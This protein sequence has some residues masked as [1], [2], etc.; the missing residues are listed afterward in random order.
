MVMGLQL[1]ACTTH[2]TVLTVFVVVGLAVVEAAEHNK[3]GPHICP[4]SNL[5]APKT[6]RIREWEAVVLKIS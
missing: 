3:N 4:Y 1:L 6:S 2:D 5:R